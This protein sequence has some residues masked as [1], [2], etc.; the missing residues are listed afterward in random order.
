MSYGA[1]AAFVLTL[2]TASSAAAVTI[3]ADPPGPRQ[4]YALIEHGDAGRD[5]M[6]ISR[7]ASGFSIVSP[8]DL[9]ASGFCVLKTEE[10]A[11]CPTLGKR[12][13]SMLGGG[14]DLLVY[15]APLDGFI[16][17]G[18]GNDRVRAGT[19]AD[20][21]AGQSGN[22]YVDGG[23]GRDY[24]PGGAGSDRL[25]GQA[26]S[27]RLKGGP[28]DDLLIGGA[29]ADKFSGGSG[30]DL[31]KARNRQRDSRIDCGDGE[32]R[33]VVDRHLDPRPVNCESVILK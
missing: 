33:A 4:P 3:R 8:T 13:L 17:A 23:D 21:L 24:L 29:S 18:S 15:T 6:S 28:G 16:T 31:L 30:N 10:E 5:V 20:T 27:D 25:R 11:K 32:D 22:D 1:V 7:V 9:E 19:G 26:D 2:V 14:S 12:F